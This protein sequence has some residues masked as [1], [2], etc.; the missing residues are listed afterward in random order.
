MAL[1]LPTHE[2]IRTFSIDQMI[3]LI[4]HIYQELENGQ[5]SNF[6]GYNNELHAVLENIVLPVWKWDPDPLE[7]QGCFIVRRGVPDLLTSKAFEAKDLAISKGFLKKI[8]GQS[9]SHISLTESGKALEIDENFFPL[10]DLDIS[11]IFKR[12]SL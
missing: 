4:L 10:V 8:H 9:E 12:K 5:V 1:R 3:G 2:Q 7:L 11:E 6:V